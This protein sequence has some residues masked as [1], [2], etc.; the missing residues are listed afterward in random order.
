[1][2]AFSAVRRAGKRPVLIESGPYGTMCARVGCMPSKLLIAA[3]DAAHAVRGSGKFGVQVPELAIDGEQVMKRVREERDRFVSFAVNTVEGYDDD[4][5]LTGRARFVSDTRLYIDNHTQLDVQSTVIATGSTPFIPGDFSH[6]GDRLIVNDDVFDWQTL[7][8]RILVVGT[9]VIGMELGQA[10]A[11]LG[12]KTCLINRGKGLAGISDPAVLASASEIFEGELDIRCNTELDDTELS[13]NGVKVRLVTHADNGQTSVSEFEVDCILMAAGRRPCLE[14]LELEATSIA[15]DGTA[16]LPLDADTLQL[17]K[18]PIFMAGDVTGQHPLLH[19]AADDGFIAG[20]NAAHFP[21]LTPGQRRAPIGIVFCDPQ[22]ARIGLTW[23]QLPDPDAF[24]VGE[25]DFSNQGR[26][27][28]MN[29]NRGLLRIYASRTEGRLLGA[30]M[31]GPNMEHIAH[32]LAWA[33]QQDLTIPA[34]LTMPFYHP[35]IEEGLR[36]ALRQAAS[37]L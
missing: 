30:E 23:S 3:S 4:S 35:V 11:R 21:D 5:K 10:L 18:A 24:V 33:W 17:G 20:S 6:L 7:P 26:S 31:V 22:I 2:T 37:Q 13:E 27:R 8:R 28:I 12:V 16:A 25:I 36:T 1:M 14:D 32:L 29:R 15:W 9:G 19:E 34:M